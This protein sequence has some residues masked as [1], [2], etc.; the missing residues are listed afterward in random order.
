M[1]K[2]LLIYVLFFVIVSATQG[3]VVKRENTSKHLSNLFNMFSGLAIISMMLIF[4]DFI[5]VCTQKV[6]II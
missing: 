5:I 3:T 2:T 1:R 4:I 6:S